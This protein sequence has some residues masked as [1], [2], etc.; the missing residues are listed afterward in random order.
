MRSL[1][2]VPFQYPIIVH[3]AGIFIDWIDE[4]KAAKPFRVHTERFEKIMSE[5]INNNTPVNKFK[6]LNKQRPF[7]IVH[8]ELTDPY[9]AEKDIEL[10]ASQM[11]L[12]KRELFQTPE[13]IKDRL[14]DDEIA[15]Y[16]IPAL[17]KTFISNKWDTIF[18]TT[19]DEKSL[20]YYKV[21]PA[22]GSGGHEVELKEL[23]IEDAKDSDTLINL[24]QQIEIDTG[25]KVERR[26]R[27]DD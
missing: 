18:L 15:L 1:D 17:D 6:L 11:A 12:Y 13:L 5:H 7:R 14:A 19:N 24:S 4:I 25:L 23:R 27:Y 20:V 8:Y 21:L 9:I 10:R 16:K 2:H 3:A 26:E 22:R